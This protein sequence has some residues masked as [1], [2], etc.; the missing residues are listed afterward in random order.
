MVVIAG[1]FIYKLGVAIDD[2]PI[3]IF[4]YL[5]GWTG[6]D[7]PGKFVLKRGIVTFLSYL[8]VDSFLKTHEFS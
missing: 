1:M 5:D 7:K 6:R 3:K 4:L 2:E 8:H